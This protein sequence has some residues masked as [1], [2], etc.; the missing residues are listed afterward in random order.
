MKKFVHDFEVVS[1]IRLNAQH[2]VLELRC[3][4]KLP[5]IMPG[6]FAEVRMDKSVTTYLRR[7]FSIHY[8]DYEQNTI[9]FLVKQFGEGTAKLATIAIGEIIN[10]VYPLGTGFAMP[11][12]GKA[13][14]V[15]GGCGVAPLLMLAKHLAGKGIHITTLIGGRGADD[16]L[17]AEKYQKFGDVLVSTEDGTIGEKGMVTSHSL[18]I[19][20]LQDFSE[21]YTCGPEPMMKAIA[22]LAAKDGI[23]C[24]VSL[25]NT[26]ACGIG[27]C[28]CCV[29][30]TIEG[31]KCVCTEGPVFD[32]NFLANWSA[33]A[34]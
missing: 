30:E 1:N 5:S 14:L 33:S 8:V 25:E 13:L 26:M 29:V 27:V 22:A 20:G 7:P 18:I 17:Q 12:A 10:I 15:G 19:E 31:N 9:S 21:V 23:P 11:N 6:Q 28:L 16:I 32:S 34:C 2:F 4:E 24:Q 3:N